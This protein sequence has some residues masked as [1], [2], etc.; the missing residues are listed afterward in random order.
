[1]A[2]QRFFDNM[3]NVHNSTNQNSSISL[4]GIWFDTHR[5]SS[6]AFSVNRKQPKK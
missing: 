4:L 2:P 6:G 3:I 5:R 1:M